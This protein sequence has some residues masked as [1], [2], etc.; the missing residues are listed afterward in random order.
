MSGIPW[1]TVRPVL[2]QVLELDGP[3]R[4]TRIEELCGDNFD[5]ATEVRRLVALDEQE[6]G[7]D[8][9]A[10]LTDISFS[11]FLG[12]P[13]A[14]G[15][16]DAHGG[17][18]IER[19]L[20]SG[21]MGRVYL[22]RQAHP[23]RAVA[24][25]VMRPDLATEGYMARFRREQ[26]ILAN[27][28]HP[29]IAQIFEAGLWTD[30]SGEV[31]PFFAME[32][33]PGARTLTDYCD[34]AALTRGEKVKLFH[35]VCDAVHD[36]HSRGVVHRDLKP[37][38]VLVDEDGKA[39]V[40][41][42]G[43]ARASGSE[44]DGADALTR[45]GEMIGTVRFMSPEQ[46]GGNEVDAKSDVYSLGVV[47]Y[48]VLC[49]RS[50]YG[51]VSEEFAP[52]ALAIT[53]A[54][55]VRPSLIEPGLRGDLEWVILRCLE[56]DPARRYSDAGELRDDLAAFMQSR[57]V[58][59][60]P[61]SL[62]YRMRRFVSRNRLP[63]ALAALFTTGLTVAGV[64]SAQLFLEARDEQV[65]RELEARNAKFARESLLSAITSL[66]SRAAERLRVDKMLE[67]A[68]R[69]AGVVFK[70]DRAG[71]ITAR[72]ALVYS[73]QCVGMIEAASAEATRCLSLIGK[74]A[75]ASDIR[76]AQLRFCLAQG[77]YNQ[78]RP[79][80]ALEQA[81]ATLQEATKLGGPECP[82]AIR[83]R[84][85]LGNLLVITR[86]DVPA[87]Q[88]L[89][90]KARESLLAR[91]DP[92]DE[93]LLRVEGHLAICWTLT[94]R[95]DE[96]L[97]MI[98]SVIARSAADGGSANPAVIMLRLDEANAL[99]TLGRAED[100]AAAAETSL[101]GIEAELPADHPLRLFTLAA[102]SFYV[103]RT[104]DYERALQM[105]EPNL[106]L[107]AKVW[108][109]EHPE[110]LKAEDVMADALEWTGRP[111][112]SLK[113]RRAVLERAREAMGSDAVQ[114]VPY[115]YG[116][117]AALERA[118]KLPEAI[119]YYEE[120]AP[121]TQKAY[122]ASNPSVLG[123]QLKLAVHYI[124]L[125]RLADAREMLATL[126]Q[127]RDSGAKG[128]LGDVW[129]LEGRIL[130]AEERRDDAREPLRRALEWFTARDGATSQS[131]AA[132]AAALRSCGD[133][134][135]R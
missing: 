56:K 36:A 134:R 116:F 108:G 6:E 33:V 102:T 5:L 48:E 119:P 61:P 3:E 27:L 103:A 80:E 51:E 50:P 70:D 17:F 4:E 99:A 18:Q 14:L 111:A 105:L 57:P 96:G 53:G 68:S 13:K 64:I 22:A 15:A 24:L 46:V 110:T 83:A 82:G 7:S 29:G 60:G 84:A 73:M 97:P 90:M 72:V 92:N 2:E 35:D 52:L 66:Q 44:S 10:K 100:A 62:T 112:E 77:A 86:A 23:N 132:A 120:V 31:W 124:D 95:A 129:M 107:L 106:P 85:D 69:D 34:H 39:K 74:D 1:K 118:E 87:G 8:A 59:A 42:F 122:G 41:D 88:E 19:E 113:R 104:G 98:Q 101:A 78:G 26:S 130:I 89:L 38:N 40:I 12:L 114:L 54:D 58:M 133:G 117:A 115:L 32:Y 91:R 49:R 131:A 135:E 75:D 16:G 47:L 126:Q 127:Q 55:P 28:R 121:L 94:G 63:V 93:L 9:V 21:G 123:L 67:Q 30:Q 25:K 37:G 43:V 128:M 20:G 79:R 109:P 71:E 125:D 65:Q 45:T 11:D 81:Q 76:V